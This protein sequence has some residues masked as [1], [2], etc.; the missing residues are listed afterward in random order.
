[1]GQQ[2]KK[3]RDVPDHGS[4]LIDLLK[5]LPL[6]GFERSFK[7]SDGALF[8]NRYL[9]GLHKSVIPP[10]VLST[11]CD[12]IGMPLSHR[13]SMGENLSRASTLHFGFEQGGDSD[14]YKVYLEFAGALARGGGPH[15]PVLLHLAYKWDAM[16]PEIAMIAEYLCYQ[17]LSPPSLMARHAALYPD[18]SSGAAREA[19]Q[20]IIAL[21]SRRTDD[22]LMY[23]EVREEG[24]PR[25]SF[26]VKLHEAELRV[27]EIEIQLD[28]LRRHY[29]ISPTQYDPL[30]Q[31][32]RG[33]RLAHI[34]GGTNRHGRDFVTVYYEAEAP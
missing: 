9:L 26:D 20:E 33:S 1:M 23:L 29:A 3:S 7:M 10:H 25:F 15:E 28:A 13:R 18:Q 4:L 24:N 27:Q 16:N 32:I 21:A 17:G 19:T 30:F 12:E 22:D 14:I 31:Q 11:I 34:S 2:D 5:N 6:E 8:A